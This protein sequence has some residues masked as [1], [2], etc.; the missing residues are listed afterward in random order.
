MINFQAN[1]DII[2]GFW[3]TI[4][5]DSYGWGHKT[6]HDFCAIFTDKVEIYSDSLNRSWFCDKDMTPEK[7]S[8]ELVWSILSKEIMEA[9][10]ED[11]QNRSI[12]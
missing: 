9:I 4:T 2:N 11:A 12:G 3:F 10:E 1:P 8:V 5:T 6:E 7:E